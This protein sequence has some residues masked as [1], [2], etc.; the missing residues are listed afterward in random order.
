MG[1]RYFY[2]D[3]THRHPI[4]SELGRL[5]AQTQGFEQ[6]EI[7]EVNPWPDSHHVKPGADPDLVGRFNDMFYGPQ[8]YG[9]VAWKTG[10]TGGG[11]SNDPACAS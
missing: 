8:D 10:Q 9:I 2:L 5:L 1:A 7:L 3:P 11:L 4:P 6:V